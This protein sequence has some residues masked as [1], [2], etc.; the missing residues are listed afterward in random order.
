M[1]FNI[2][3]YILLATTT[4]YTD[5][6]LSISIVVVGYIVIT[7]LIENIKNNINKT[8]NKFDTYAIILITIGIIY[9]LF[10]RLI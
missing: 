6:L 1:F 10:L 8:K 7:T 5:I 9:M 4:K 2:I 3:I